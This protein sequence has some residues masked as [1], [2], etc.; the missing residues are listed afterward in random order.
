MTMQMAM[1]VLA[2]LVIVVSL[3]LIGGENFDELIVHHLL[4][5]PNV[6]PPIFS[7]ARYMYCE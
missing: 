2:N 5:L 4:I 3:V 1:N 7:H 6:S